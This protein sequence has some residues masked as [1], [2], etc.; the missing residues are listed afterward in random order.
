MYNYRDLGLDFVIIFG[1]VGYG[2]ILFQNWNIIIV[3]QEF[4]D[5]CIWDYGQGYVVGGGSIFNG[6]VMICG[7]R[8]D[9]DVWCMLGN[10]GWSWYGMFCYFKKSENFIVCVVLED[11]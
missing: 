3:L 8:Y 7:V 1:F 5:N 4:L 2:F 10:F 6:F 11:S 9:Y